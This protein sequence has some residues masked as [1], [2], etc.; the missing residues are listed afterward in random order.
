MSETPERYAQDN[1]EPFPDQQLAEIHS[2]IR[3]LEERDYE[4]SE[5]SNLLLDQ[6]TQTSDSLNSLVKTINNY[7]VE[8]RAERE[9][10]RERLGLIE[11]RLDAERERILACEE[12]FNI[13]QQNIER[14]L[15]YW[16][17][18]TQVMVVVAMTKGF[19]V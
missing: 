10:E 12:R 16:K 5:R 14:L 8:V 4:F 1:G 15:Q 6:I 17:I 9:A 19:A 7:V 13:M 18:V 3:Q 2:T 11:M